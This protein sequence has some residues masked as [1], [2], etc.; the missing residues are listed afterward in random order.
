MR[1]GMLAAVLVVMAASAA[2][3]EIGQPILIGK[4][5]DPQWSP[6]ER[7]IAFLEGDK[8]MVKRL[9][10]PGEAR[11]LYTGPILRYYWLDDS[12]LA[13]Q[14]R[15][16]DLARPEPLKV[17]KIVRVSLSGESEVLAY[18][19]LDASRGN[20]ADLRL[21]RFADGTVGFYEG[22]VPPGNCTML[23]A[24]TE[25]QEGGEEPELFL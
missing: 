24:R 1:K 21:K 4:G 6:D 20:D 13:T 22:L 23:S 3:A 5:R 15:K 2:V 19:S 8:L 11:Y 16:M 7:H 10:S 12:T 14:E 17:A 9:D 18:D 25:S